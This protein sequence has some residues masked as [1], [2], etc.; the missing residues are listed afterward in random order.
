MMS[1]EVPDMTS[2]AAPDQETHSIETAGLRGRMSRHRV[3]AGVASGFLL[4]TSFPPVEWSWLAWIALAPLFWLATLRGARFKT[5]LAAW[6]GGLVFWL[7]AARV[8]ADERRQRLARLV[9]DGSGVFPVVA[10][11]PRPDPLGRVSPPGPADPGRAHHLGRPGVHPGLFLERLS[12]V[13]PGSQPVPP[14]L[15]DP[16][17]GFHRLAGDQPA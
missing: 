15:P 2:V 1:N 3:V 5:Y 14:P 9:P 17:R 11:L 4:W 10:R 7:L 16:D 13:L 12:L 6:A 8:G